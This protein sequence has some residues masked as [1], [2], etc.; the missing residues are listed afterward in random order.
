MTS[1]TYYQCSV[2]IY[3]PD[4]DNSSL[5]V[6]QT[7]TIKA[8]VGKPV[9][10]LF[11][12]YSDDNDAA[13]HLLMCPVV[14]MISCEDPQLV[15]N[16]Q[17]TFVCTPPLTCSESTICLDNVNGTEII[18]SQVFLT[19]DTEISDTT[20]EII[21]TITD[22]IGKILVVSRSVELPISL[23]CLPNDTEME[24][25]LKLNILTNQPCVEFSKIFTGMYLALLT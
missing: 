3:F 7:I 17:I 2:N 8:D 23:Y 24:N 15:Q 12:Q 14:V 22:H 1:S 11:Q 25:P 10:N 13:L 6:L 20:A 18:E 19:N 16:I 9:Q 5:G 21:F 4:A